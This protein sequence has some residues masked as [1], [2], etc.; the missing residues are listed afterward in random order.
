VKKRRVLPAFLVLS[1]CLLSCS[2]TR[3]IRRPPALRFVDLILSK[4]IEV[5]AFTAVPKNPTNVFSPKDPEVVAFLKLENFW[6]VHTV[7]W[8]WFEP[9]G[10][11]YY[12]TGDYPMK[13]GEGKYLREISAWHKLS[14]R[15]EEAGNLPG[16][17]TVKIFF[18]KEVLAS[19]NF[20]IE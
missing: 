19:K 6:G 16:D 15:G 17:W 12:S 2:T 5:E 10:N 7:R 18:D 11:L 1:L 3:E 8:E 13:S 4:E 9:D 14:I 20:R